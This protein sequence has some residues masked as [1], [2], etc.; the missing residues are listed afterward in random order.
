MIWRESKPW[1][2]PALVALSFTMIIAVF[3]K[4][5]PTSNTWSFVDQVQGEDNSTSAIFKTLTINPQGDQ[6]FMHAASIVPTHEGVLAVWYSGTYEGSRDAEITSSRFDGNNWSG[7]SAIANSDSLEDEIGLH[8]K[9]VANPVAFRH[10]NGELWL[11]FAVSRLSGWATCEILLK[12]S[13]DNGRT[14]SPATRL[15]ASPFANISHLS[16]SPP[17]QMTGGLLGLPV[18]H[19]FLAKYPVFLVIDGKGRVV[20]KRRMG[21]GGYV[22]FQPTIVTKS[23]TSAVAFFRRLRNNAPSIMMTKTED[24]GQTWSTAVATNLPNPG[25]AVSAVRFE[26]NR[27]LLAFNDDPKLENNITLA[28]SDFEGVSW[29][30]IGI[31]ADEATEKSEK[32]KLTY[33]YILETQPGIF[34]LVFTRSPKAKYNH[35]K[36]K[37]EVERAIRHVRLSNEWIHTQVNRVQ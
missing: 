2:V 10:Q 12:R 14:W 32:Y 26:S 28:V 36:F 19:E 20:D 23:E 34:D 1:L 5:I 31:V 11:A 29:R 35:P 18:Y 9:S 13:H 8:V 37:D 25:G 33:P 3:V 30:R 16:K 24:A 22:G 27:I 6:R 4:M 7:T 21:E 15:Y 17:V